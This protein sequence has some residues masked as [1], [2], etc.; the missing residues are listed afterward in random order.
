MVIKRYVNV[1]IK[2]RKKLSPKFY[3]EKIKNY[4]SIY[5]FK[6]VIIYQTFTSV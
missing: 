5:S 1:F 2:N 6:F 3:L 4:S